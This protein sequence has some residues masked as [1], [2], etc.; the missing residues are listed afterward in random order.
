VTPGFFATMQTPILEGRDFTEHDSAA[1]MKVAV[2]SRTMAQKLWPHQSAI[3]KHI[4]CCAGDNY[5]IIGV[6]SDVH[7]AGPASPAGF[8]IYTSVEQEPPPAMFFLLR[9]SGDPL[10]L[11]DS[12]RRTV[13]AIDPG[14]AVS[15][16]TSLETLAQDSIAGQR[17]S[18][19]ITCLLGILALVLSSVG[20]YGVISYAVSRRGR[21]FGIRMALGAD[22]AAIVRLLFSGGLRMILPGIVIGAGLV[23]AMRAWMDSVLG[24]TGT[25]PL[26]LFG[27]GIVLCAV[28][29][30]A[31]M[32][33]A[34]RA[35]RIEPMEALRSE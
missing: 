27:A 3:G 34:R 13:A 20:V 19:M 10:A 17:T 21:E 28:A 29:A 14:Q 22:R 32:V 8:A 12:V 16:I 35:S 9:T 33:P 4:M 23:V 7:Y 5:T 25:N 24:A 26:A 1:S 11:A 15:N 30:V 6:A 31:T 2:I 18:T